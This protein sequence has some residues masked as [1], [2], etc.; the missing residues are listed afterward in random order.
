MLVL[1][2]VDGQSF[3]CAT[4]LA[5][6]RTRMARRSEVL[7]LDVEVQVGSL[8]HYVAHGALPVRALQPQH[9][10]LDFCTAEVSTTQIGKSDY[11]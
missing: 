9:Q 7:T 8:H 5:T 6:L 11:K 1:G 4:E 3:E 10:S 2:S